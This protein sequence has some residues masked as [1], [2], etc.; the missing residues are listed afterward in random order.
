MNI[1]E[2]E[3]LALY[4]IRTWLGEDWTLK[5]TRK[6]TKGGSCYRGLKKIEL[7]RKVVEVN[8][9]AG[10][11]ELILHEIA[12]GRMPFGPFKSHGPMWQEIARSIGCTGDPHPNIRWPQRTAK[13][14]RRVARMQR[15]ASTWSWVTVR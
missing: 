1:A 11:R 3:P 6:L 13:L 9:E 5:W 8:D 15:G 10:V 4:L 12:H 14:V 7:S 2:A